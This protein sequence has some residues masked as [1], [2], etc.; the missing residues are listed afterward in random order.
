MS[1]S[2][3]EDEQLTES[4]RVVLLARE[5]RGRPK[6]EGVQR[7]R[8]HPLFILG[9]T[10]K[11]GEESNMGCVAYGG[12]KGP[13]S[14]RKA[15]GLGREFKGEADVRD[16]CWEQTLSS[17]SV[18]CC[19][20]SSWHPLNCWELIKGT[21]TYF[22][23]ELPLCHALEDV[24]KGLFVCCLFLDYTSLAQRFVPELVNFLLGVLHLAIPNKETQGRILASLLLFSPLPPLTLSWHC[25][26]H[27]HWQGS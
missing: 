2:E 23:T 3:E 9:H 1:Q 5:F 11:D 8:A 14:L 26:Y 19:Y 21:H 16:G 6:G 17:S 12:G 13:D 22:L 4:G 20:L 27:N 18:G 7:K 15:Q 25:H 10:G 24:V